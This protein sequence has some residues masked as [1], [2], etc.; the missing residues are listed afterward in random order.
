[1]KIAFVTH[2]GAL[3]PE[4]QDA[5]SV[6]GTFR[7]GCMAAP[8]TIDLEGYPRML[9]VIDGIG[10]CAGGALAARIIAETLSEA[11]NVK[12]LF[13]EELDIEG[14]EKAIGALLEA[15]ERK[16]ALA[17]RDAPEMAQ[18]GAVIAGVLI[19]ER[20]ALIFNCGDCR[21]YRVSGG[22]SERLS[23]EHSVVEALYEMGE[24][25]EDGMRS[26]PMKNIVTS[27]V[28]PDTGQ[29]FELYVRTVSRCHG[30]AFFICSDGV[31]E[32]LD[33]RRLAEWLTGP[34][35]DASGL[36]DDLL[37]SGCRDNVSF[38]WQTG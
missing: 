4:N 8:E 26:H 33:S 38:I 13:S 7:A 2:S 32:A 16:M 36:L 20:S 11:A 21:V 37:S 24:I 35:M 29:R 1:M 31:W 3:R 14:D 10:G 12:N 6:A 15:S 5:L 30:D 19:R 18:M 25:D 22:A 9:A 34:D 28:S 17:A 27:S 23:R